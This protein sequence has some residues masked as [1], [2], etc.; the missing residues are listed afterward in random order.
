MSMA[1]EI[2][3]WLD[4]PVSYQQGVDLYEKYGRLPRLKMLLKRGGDTPRNRDTLKYELKKLYLDAGPKKPENIKTV[5]P[6]NITPPAGNN[7]AAQAGN[8]TVAHT[9]NNTQGAP[10]KTTLDADILQPI[11][12]RK[13][14]LFKEYVA[15]FHSLEHLP[16][17]KRK[18]AAMECLALMDKNEELWRQ[19]HFYEQHGRLP[20]VQDKAVPDAPDTFKLMTRRNTLRSYISRDTKKLAT[21]KKPESIA[22]CKHRL[23]LYQAELTDIESKI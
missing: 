7:T 20:A 15:L 3:A 6:K 8:N 9:G 19:I 13:N 14:Q 23:E 4:A 10:G 2:K 18:E 5:A 22:E 16:E 1:D 21:L 12:K 11:I 17:K